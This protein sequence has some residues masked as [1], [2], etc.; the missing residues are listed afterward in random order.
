MLV[1]A[2]GCLSKKDNSNQMH[3]QTGPWSVQ[4]TPRRYSLGVKLE[5]S[6]E[7]EYSFKSRVQTI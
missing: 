4:I 7:C 3:N 6:L 1:K 5:I 2:T